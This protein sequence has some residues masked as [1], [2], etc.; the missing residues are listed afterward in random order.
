MTRILSWVIMVPF[1]LVVIVF[2]AVNRDLV[3]LN[4][5]PFPNEITVPVFTMVLAVFIF[6]FLF[7][8]IVAWVSAS[9]QR[10]RARNALW[11]AETS[12]RELRSLNNKLQERERELQ[13]VKEQPGADVK[14]LSAFSNGQ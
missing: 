11:R 2:S 12:E 14:S 5:W 7:G 3:T 6:G 4:L 1:A 8:A 10:R 13:A 9:S